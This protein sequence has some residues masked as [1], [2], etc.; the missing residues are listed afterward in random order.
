MHEI[1]VIFIE[2]DTCTFLAPKTSVLNRVNVIAVFG[3]LFPCGS[4]VAVIVGYLLTRTF[5]G[6][7]AHGVFVKAVLEGVHCSAAYNF[8]WWNIPGCCH[9]VG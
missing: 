2:S 3:V 8:T 5:W 7:S 9:V 6:F 1:I 4:C